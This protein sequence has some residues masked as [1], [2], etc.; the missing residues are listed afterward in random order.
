MK[1]ALSFSVSVLVVLFSFTQVANASVLFGVSGYSY[2]SERGDQRGQWINIGRGYSGDLKYVYFSIDDDASD[3]YYRFL[4]YECNSYGSF[5]GTNTGE[6][7]GTSGSATFAPVASESLTAQWQVVAQNGVGRRLVTAD[8]TYYVKTAFPSGTQ[9]AHTFSTTP[10]VLSPTKYYW[11]HIQPSTGTSGNGSAGSVALY[12]I[13][14]TLD[15]VD[16]NDMSTHH[17]VNGTDI[18]TQVGTAYHYGADAPLTL[19]D[20][21]FYTPASSSSQSSLSGART[22][23]EG[24][25]S[26]SSAFGIPYGLCYISAFLFVPSADSINTFWAN[27]EL[28]KQVAPWSYM[29]DFQSAWTTA[30]SNSQSFPTWSI[31]WNVMGT[32]SASLVLLSSAS[33]TRWLDSSSLATLRGISTVGMYIGFA[34]Y[35]WR[36]GRN[37]LKSL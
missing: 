30:T 28:V 16:G 8:F 6:N 3:N 9:T 17:G 1:K 31:P 22:F 11:L 18:D 34:F 7:C 13:Q 12:G 25:A 23:C 14:A 20:V 35:L 21:G 27:A 10:I 37:V 19:Q 32:G 2:V 24:V 36:R 4:L 5:A 33:W 29:T 15:D 26:S